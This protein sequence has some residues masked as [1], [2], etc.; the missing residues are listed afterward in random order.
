MKTS[1]IVLTVLCSAALASRADVFVYKNKVTYSI[2]GDGGTVKNAAAGWPVLD[3][4]AN[5]TQV[6]A[7]PKLK[8][9]TIVPMQSHEYETTQANGREYSFIVQHDV[10]SD[11]NGLTHIDTGGA[12]GQDV[13]M[14]V[15][16]HAWSMPK[17]FKWG[18]RSMYPAGASGEMKYEES[19]GTFTFD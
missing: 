15:N 3:D 1:L 9:F 7:Y 8:Q 18:G 11:G 17:S 14:D 12:I 19:S 5:L 13:E 10:W 4:S 6:L 2:T 16:G